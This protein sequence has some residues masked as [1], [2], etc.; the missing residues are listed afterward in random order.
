MV[1]EK[2]LSS[3]SGGLY[4]DATMKPK[5]S[6]EQITAPHTPSSNVWTSDTSKESCV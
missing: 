1:L 3:E 6:I 4:T 5:V 2:L